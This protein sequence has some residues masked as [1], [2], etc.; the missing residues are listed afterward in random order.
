MT[1]AVA[2]LVLEPLARIDV[3]FNV[4]DG[5]AAWPT[6][7]VR[8][9]VAALAEPSVAVIVAGADRGRAR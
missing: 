4:T 8:V 7:C 6:V 3:G 1:C 9:A 2:V 5:F